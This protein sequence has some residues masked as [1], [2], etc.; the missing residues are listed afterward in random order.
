MKMTIEQIEAIR[1]LMEG[2]TFEQTC[3]ACPYAKTCERYQL[4]WG[5]PAWEEEMGEEV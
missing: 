1:T 5:C 3:T 4:Y 2:K